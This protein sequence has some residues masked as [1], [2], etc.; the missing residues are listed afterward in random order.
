MCPRLQ[1]SEPGGP[2]Y[3][4][5]IDLDGDEVGR[6]QV[7]GQVKLG[8]TGQAEIV[9]RRESVLALFGKKVRHAVR[10]G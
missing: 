10:L 4:V 8:M 5:R 9:I 6:G 2:M 7:R 1:G 3:T